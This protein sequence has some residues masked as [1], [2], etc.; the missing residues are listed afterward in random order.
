MDRIRI[1][2]ETLKVLEKGEY[3]ADNEVVKL[4]M[5]SYKEV[6]VITPSV[7]EELLSKDMESASNQMCN[8]VITTEDSLEA[9]IRYE[10]VLVMNFANAHKAGGGFLGGARAQEEEIC[11]RSTLYA[12]IASDKAK[13]MYRYNNSHLSSV[14]SD[15]MLISPNVYVW[16]DVGTYEPRLAPKKVGVVTVP[17]PNR[18]GAAML[19]S[20]KLIVDTFERRIRIMLKAAIGYGYKNL[21]LGAWGCGAFGNDPR[22]VANCFKKV[23]IEEG[24]GLFFEEV[25]FAIYGSEDGRNITAWR[26]VM[27]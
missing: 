1:A 27:T 13:D 10:D 25:C 8:I 19:A 21:V 11:R 2:R 9:G 26:E 12:S 23:I 7:G 24:L 14:E 4:P 17:A 22:M 15:Y 16:R 6:I 20:K 18:R 5:D 3:I